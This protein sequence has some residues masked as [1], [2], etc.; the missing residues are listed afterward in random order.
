MSVKGEKWKRENSFFL[1]TKTNKIQYN[2]KCSKCEH[3]CKQ[4]FK[5]NLIFCPF[6]LP[7]KN[8][9]K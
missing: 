8:Y 2:S 1:N 3:N 4:S 9:K 7:I 5:A 6:Y